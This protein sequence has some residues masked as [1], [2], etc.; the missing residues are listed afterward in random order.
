MLLFLILKLSHCFH[1]KDVILKHFKF[2]LVYNGIL[3]TANKNNVYNALFVWL[4]LMLID[5]N[6]KVFNI[7]NLT[8]IFIHKLLLYYCIF[9]NRSQKN[10]PVIIVNILMLKSYFLEIIFDL[11]L[12]LKI[13][14]YLPLIP[15]ILKPT[16]FYALFTQLQVHFKLYIVY[17]IYP[18]IKFRK[19]FKFL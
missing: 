8:L 3:L 1:L 12:F 7:I 6:K 11:S 4:W 14:C 5:N 9:Y 19:L 18:S 16:N 17:E 15:C 13:L 2:Y 10:L